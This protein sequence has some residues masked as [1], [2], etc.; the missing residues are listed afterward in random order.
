VANPTFSLA[1]LWDGTA[2]APAVQRVIENLET[3]FEPSAVS[4]LAVIQLPSMAC[5]HF[6]VDFSAYSRATLTQL[7]IDSTRCGGRFIELLR[8]PEDKREAFKAQFLTPVQGSNLSCGSFKEC[9]R[10]LAEHLGKLAAGR[11]EVPTVKPSPARPRQTGPD[12]RQAPRFDVNLQVEFDSEAD[13]AR[14]HAIN[15]SKGG[16]FV[17]TTQRPALNS[18]LGL[19]IK[20]PNGQVI[21]TRARVVH[22]VDHPENGGV[23]LAFGREDPAF[24]G[25]LD[26]YLAEIQKK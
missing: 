14:E 17:R 22:V 25:A 1:I 23:G 18:E 2:S 8:I 5:L 11:A 24:G 9:S 26:Q 20:L 4:N 15:I 16:V 10:P 21:Q 12:A 19:R 7:E 6:T 3:T 13:F